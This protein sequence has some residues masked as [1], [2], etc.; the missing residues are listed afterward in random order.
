[1]KSGWTIAQHTLFRILLGLYLLQ[2]FVTLLPW[3]TELF[4]NRGTLPAASESPLIHLFPNILA[5]WD[6]PRFVTMLLVAG[7]VMSALLIFR[8]WDRPAALFLWYLWACLLGRNPLI[9]NPALP[10]IGWLL[11]LYAAIPKASY[12]ERNDS[13]SNWS[14][15]EPA[16]ALAWALLAVSYSYSGY[17]KLVS[18]SWVDGSAL[19]RILE[20]PLARPTILRELLLAMPGGVLRVATWAA[21]ALELAYAPLALFR[22]FRPWIWTAMVGLHVGLLFLISFADLTIAMLL[23]HLFTFD[24]AWLRRSQI[25]RTVI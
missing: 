23:V 5:V 19:A 21:L 3:G 12:L 6:Q 22:R 24:S 1:M 8:L 25:S 20:N 9:S 15:P 17:T 14:M 11:L 16:F 10:F 4:S 7:I 18:P 2:H 13:R